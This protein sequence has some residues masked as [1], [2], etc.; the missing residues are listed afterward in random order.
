MTTPSLRRARATKALLDRH[1]AKVLA[2]LDKTTRS[3]VAM[4]GQAYGEVIGDLKRSAAEAA[5]AGP[6]SPADFRAGRLGRSLS[7]VDDAFTR[8]AGQSGIVIRHAVPAVVT[9]SAEVQALNLVERGVSSGVSF[10]L[11]RPEVVDAIVRRS[12]ETIHQASYLLAADAQD[13]LKRNLVRG[14]AGGLGPR[15][16]ARMIVAETQTAFNGGLARATTLARTELLDASREGARETYKAAGDLV[17]GW[18][19]LATLSERTCP[20]C[21]AMHNTIHKVDEFLDGHQN[22][23]CTQ[24]PIT[25]YDD[26]VTDDLGDPKAAFDSLPRAK[27]EA[28]MGPG[29]MRYLDDGGDFRALARQ[30][31]NPGWRTSRTPTPVRDL[32]AGGAGSHVPAPRAPKPTPP[33]APTVSVSIPRPPD[34]L[35][36]HEKVLHAKATATDLLAKMDPANPASVEAYKQALAQHKGY[37]KT[38]ADEQKAAHNKAA[39]EAALAKAKAEAE[40]ARKALEVAQAAKASG[41]VLRERDALGHVAERTNVLTSPSDYKKLDALRRYKGIGYRS[42]NERLRSRLRITGGDKEVDDGLTRAFAE[43]V[44]ATDVDVQVW[45]GIRVNLRAVDG[46]SLV[47]GSQVEDLAWGSVSADVKISEGF[48][49]DSGCMMEIVM[50]RGSEML[51]VAKANGQLEEY[52]QEMILRPGARFVVESISTHQRRYGGTVPLYRLRFLGY[53]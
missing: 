51:H 1:Q 41:T 40:A 47:P 35:T 42:L 3:L 32:P 43:D 22:C 2:P 16:T 38:F 48:S 23:R 27:Q 10:S 36:T 30:Q 25:K 31:T 46:S 14:I 6:L 53:R 18:R 24:A 29:R 45:R 37:L 8:L 39:A 9:G 28:I 26:G 15:D 5:L 20:A 50:P 11:L 52:E 17:V 12:T 19:W 7:A 4:Y 34:H 13:S 44:T 33:P 21:W 49:G